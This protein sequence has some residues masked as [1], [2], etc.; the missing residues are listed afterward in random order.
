MEKYTVYLLINVTLQEV[1]FGMAGNLNESVD[2]LPPEIAHWD[3]LNHH[4]SNPVM[5]EEALAF[6][7]AAATIRTLQEKALKNPQG[8][9]IL[10]NRSV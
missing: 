8:K 9:T 3:L 6:E 4:I 2:T 10:L 1:F 7:E 5:I